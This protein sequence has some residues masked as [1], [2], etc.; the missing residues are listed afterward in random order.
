MRR[1]VP[2]AA[3]DTKDRIGDRTWRRLAAA[4]CSGARFFD[5]LDG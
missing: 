1:A 3:L 5:N 4:I 2:G